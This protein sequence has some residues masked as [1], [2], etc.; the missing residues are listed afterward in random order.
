MAPVTGTGVVLH[1]QNP[2]FILK[3]PQTLGIAVDPRADSWL[4]FFPSTLTPKGGLLALN[5]AA[6][7]F[8]DPGSLLS[9]NESRRRSRRENPCALPPPAPCSLLLT[10][11][12]A[13]ECHPYL[14]T[15]SL[16]AR[17]ARGPSVRE[18]LPR[19]HP[20]K[21]CW[22]WV[23]RGWLRAAALHCS[24]QLNPKPSPPGP[25]ISEEGARWKREANGRG[26]P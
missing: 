10:P 5:L 4:C 23:V 1:Q 16:S 15:G 8:L 9:Q 21:R 6:G 22:C 14:P 2:V 20:Q 11:R 17:E 24:S 13:S 26:T 3:S 7:F 19:A 25:L 12:G 18:E